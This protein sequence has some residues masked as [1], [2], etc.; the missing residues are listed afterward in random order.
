M[1]SKMVARH[2]ILSEPQVWVAEPEYQS[3][4]HAWSVLQR[5]GITRMQT[6]NRTPQHTV[7]GRSYY[8]QTSWCSCPMS[9]CPPQFCNGAGSWR[10]LIELISQ[11]CPRP[12]PAS[13]TPGRKEH[14]LF[15]VLA[16]FGRQ[17]HVHMKW[18]R[19]HG[20]AGV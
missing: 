17:R 13:Q 4:A 12:V 8:L 1:I 16:T 11:D 19:A 5:T 18:L 10:N 20:V 2:A 3:P 9:P 6:R 14:V 15:E 7:V